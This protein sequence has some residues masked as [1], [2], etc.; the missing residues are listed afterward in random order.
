MLSL[1]LFN[2]TGNVNL[3]C[4]EVRSQMNIEE[5]NKLEEK[6]NGMVN[7]LKLLK[8]ENKKLKTEMAAL[9]VDSSS[10]EEERNLIKQKVTTLIELLDSLERE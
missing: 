10:K 6:V 5:L 9:K 7:T 3:K 1:P 4:P 8:D 2:K